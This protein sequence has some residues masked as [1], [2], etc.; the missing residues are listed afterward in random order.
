MG[1]Y[2]PSVEGPGGCRP[3]GSCEVREAPGQ[4]AKDTLV[5]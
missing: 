5:P 1:L 2:C 4:K 3:V